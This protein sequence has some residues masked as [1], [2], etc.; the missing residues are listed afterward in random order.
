MS[1]PVTDLRSYSTAKRF[2][3]NEKEMIRQI[4]FLMLVVVVVC[5]GIEVLYDIE[6]KYYFIGGL[7]LEF[8]GIVLLVRSFR[9]ISEFKDYIH[10][11]ENIRG[12]SPEEI[13]TIEN[14]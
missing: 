5:F 9:N 13:Q 4:I 12:K 2:L 14:S 10:W 8:I 1:N 3:H 7:V 11:Y 6:F